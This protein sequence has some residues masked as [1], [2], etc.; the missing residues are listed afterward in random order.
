[1][2]IFKFLPCLLEIFVIINIIVKVEA[3]N[4]FQ[5][6]GHFFQVGASQGA[7]LSPILKNGF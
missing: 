3:T 7:L 1:M 4:Y 6:R 5:P 2:K